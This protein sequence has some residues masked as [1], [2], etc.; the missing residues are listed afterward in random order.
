MFRLVAERGE[1]LVRVTSRRGN[2]KNVAPT[3]A[4]NN[5][6]TGTDRAAAA[7]RAKQQRI[8]RWA[9]VPVVE[10]VEEEVSWTEVLAE[11]AAATAAAVVD[12][13]ATGSSGTS[14][15]LS[16]RMPDVFCELFSANDCADEDVTQGN[17]HNSNT[18][19]DV[20]TITSMGA[21][22]GLRAAKRRC[23]VVV[24]MHPDQATEPI[25]SPQ[26]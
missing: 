15:F 18:N 2:A 20:K 10:E 22:A 12:G 11:N 1:R 23:D 25:T 8:N 6:G 4:A 5:A 16:I 14:T 19:A 17:A 26:Q 7:A 21:S 13:A 24:G 9:V 3:P